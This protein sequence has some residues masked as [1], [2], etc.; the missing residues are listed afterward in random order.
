[1]TP[2]NKTY[3]ALAQTLLADPRIFEGNLFGVRVLKINGRPFVGLFQN[4]WLVV[5]VGEPRMQEMIAAKAGRMFDPSGKGRPMKEWIA[6]DEPATNAKKKWLAL[7]EEAK[8]FVEQQ[9]QTAQAA[10]Y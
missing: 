1:M 5:K 8:D 3:T 4:K 7:A 2:D 6:V 9:Q 10:A